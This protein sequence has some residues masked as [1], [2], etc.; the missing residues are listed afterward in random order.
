MNGS[1]DPFMALDERQPALRLY[2]PT[3][4]RSMLTFFEYQLLQ[5]DRIIYQ[6]NGKM[7]SPIS[8]L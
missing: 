3:L 8:L 6:K 2:V 5:T 7:S 4:L 1:S